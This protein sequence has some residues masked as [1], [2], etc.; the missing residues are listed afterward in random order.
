MHVTNFLRLPDDTL[1]IAFF[2][3]PEHLVMDMKS[4][5]FVNPKPALLM[6]TMQDSI[7]LIF[8]ESTVCDSG[9]SFFIPDSISIVWTLKCQILGL[10]CFESCHQSIQSP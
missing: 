1:G 8:L 7:S 3:Q 10:L 9:T 5:A 4:L 2:D 6:A